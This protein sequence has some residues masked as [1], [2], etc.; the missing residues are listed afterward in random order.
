ME[1]FIFKIAL[2]FFCFATFTYAAPVKLPG[3]IALHI[4]KTHYL[5]P[6]RLLHPYL[7]HWHMK[8][9][10]SEKAA[11]DSLQNRFANVSEC[12]ESSEA[13]VVLLLEPHMFYNPQLRVFHAEYI[14]RAYTSSGEPL[15][16]IKKQA[17]QIGDLNIAPD[18]FMEKSYTKA[19]NKVIEK[20]ATDKEFLATLDKNTKIKAGSICSKLDH[21][22]L[23]KLYY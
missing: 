12:T 19:I 17:R 14:A 16:R 11:I 22:P 7:D 9:P 13:D 3:K 2:V 21:Q 5:H 1:K 6:V 18:F 4:A 8:G 10:L 20:L 23:E 15:T